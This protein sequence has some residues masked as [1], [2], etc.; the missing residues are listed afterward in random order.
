MK[1]V[2]VALAGAV[3]VANA[4]ATPDLSERHGPPSYHHGRPGKPSSGSG[5]DLETFTSLVI[6]GD[7]YSDDSRLGYF[8]NSGGDP[9][10]VGWVEP[11]AN[12]SADGGYIWGEYVSRYAGVNKYNYA[13]SGA[14]CSNDITP[15]YFSAIDAPFPALAQYEI[16]AYIADSKYVEKNGTKFMIDPPDETVYAFW[17]GTNDLGYYAFIQDEQVEGTDLTTYVDCMYRQ[18]ERVYNNGG[19]YFVLFNIA[20]LDLAP[21]YAAPPNDI[22]ANQYWPDKPKNHTLLNGR[23]IE[24]VATVNAIFDYRTPFAVELKNR[25]PGA[26]FAVYDVHGLMLDIYNNPSDYL[27]GTAPLNVDGYVNHCNTTGGDCVANDSPDSFLWYDELHPSEQTE[28]VIAMNF[29]DVVKGAS[30]W[31]TY[32][33]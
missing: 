15:R 1:S 20:P 4:L 2:A 5:W 12:K 28:R 26:K 13:V 25:Y 23:M 9:P 10:P 17:D 19:R 7:S 11:V 32:W 21:I 6:F 8:I 24:E 22:G 16:P 31:A 27:N 3:T 14:V 30:K 29:I 33:G 18:M